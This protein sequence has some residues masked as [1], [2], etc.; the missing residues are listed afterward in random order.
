MKMFTQNIQI[1]ITKADRY[2][3]YTPNVLCSHPNSFRHIYVY[4]VF[5]VYTAVVPL[6]FQKQK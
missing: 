1:F 3:R 5:P 2:V 6:Y 4:H